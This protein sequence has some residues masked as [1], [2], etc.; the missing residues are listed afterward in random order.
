MKVSNIKRKL[1]HTMV[2]CGSGMF[3]FIVGKDMKL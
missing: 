2:L 1:K 3:E